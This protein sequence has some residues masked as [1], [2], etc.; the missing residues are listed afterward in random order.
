[1]KRELTP[2]SIGLGLFLGVIMAAAN[3]YLG[4]YGVVMRTR[5]W[6]ERSPYSSAEPLTHVPGDRLLSVDEAMRPS[7]AFAEA[8]T[9]ACYLPAG[10]R[11]VG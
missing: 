1:M 6:Y 7:P 2:L 8:I 3:V 10:L 5:R 4:L 9:R 11:V